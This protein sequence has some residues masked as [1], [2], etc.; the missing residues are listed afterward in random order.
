MDSNLI[1]LGYS[2]APKIS[3]IISKFFFRFFLFAQWYGNVNVCN[4]GE[5]KTFEIFSLIHVRLELMEKPFLVDFASLS[6]YNLAP[7]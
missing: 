1:G 5:Y 2:S 6:K 4:C 7:C 3:K